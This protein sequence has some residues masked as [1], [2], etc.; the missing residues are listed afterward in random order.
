M[1]CATRPPCGNSS[2][3]RCRHD[4]QGFARPPSGS[5]S[6]MS[7]GTM[8]SQTAKDPFAAYSPQEE[9]LLGGYA[10]LMT[11]FTALAGLFAVWFRRSGRELPDRM[12]ARDLALV[13]VAS[14]K[15]ARTITK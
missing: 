13:T 6:H 14:H 4:G 8:E 1:P 11:T 7:A 10:I 9:K 12:D 2:P 3:V 15:A 5:A